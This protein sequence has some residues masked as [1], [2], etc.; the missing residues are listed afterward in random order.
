MAKSTADLL[1]ATQIYSLRIQFDKACHVQKLVP[2][3]NEE[4][5]GE[6]YE[7]RGRR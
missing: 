5:P 6:L 3:L 1:G 7:R 4:R 2:Y